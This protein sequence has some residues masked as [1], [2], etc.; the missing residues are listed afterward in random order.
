MKTI[1]PLLIQEEV[2]K[3]PD[4]TST[5]EYLYY[6]CQHPIEILESH[7]VLRSPSP[8]VKGMFRGVSMSSFIWIFIHFLLD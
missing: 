8:T 6:N 2:N 7:K 5:P 4:Q 3:D 1:N